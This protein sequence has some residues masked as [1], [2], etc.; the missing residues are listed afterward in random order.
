MSLNR[1]AAKVDSTQREI[2]RGLR[3]AG[4]KVWTIR[5]PVDLLLRFWCNRHH[6]FCW[7]PLEVKTPDPNGKVKY[8]T[9]R[10][11]Q[12]QFIEETGTP[13]A[14]SFDEAWRKLN[15]RHHLGGI[16]IPTV[17]PIKEIA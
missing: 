1:F 14:T 5:R 13:V 9:D 2:I 11:T 6:D 8:R 15:A 17:Q 3:A 12:N 7:Q 16:Q 4:V 10:L